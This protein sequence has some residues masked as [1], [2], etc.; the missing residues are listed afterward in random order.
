MGRKRE[1]ANLLAF[2]TSDYSTFMTG[3][4]IVIDGGRM[5]SRKPDPPEVVNNVFDPIAVAQ[6]KSQQNEKKNGYP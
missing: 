3:N 1:V 6:L 2:L 5:I 4:V